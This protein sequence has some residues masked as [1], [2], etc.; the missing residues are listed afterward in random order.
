MDTR[1]RYILTLRSGA[2]YELDSDGAVL[3]RTDGPDRSW[4]YGGRWRILGLAAQWDHGYTVSLAAAA[5]G[6]PF[7]EGY[8]HDIDHGT[9]RVWGH[10]DDRRAASVRDILPVP[11]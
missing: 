3:Y 7:G 6:V 1:T 4:N 5:A 11:A 10:P 9:R 8:V 2:K